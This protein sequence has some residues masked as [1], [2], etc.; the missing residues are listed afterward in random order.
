MN[1]LLLFLCSSIWNSFGWKEYS[2]KLLP[3]MKASFKNIHVKIVWETMLCSQI[4]EGYLGARAS[5]QQGVLV[6]L[7]SSRCSWIPLLSGT[8]ILP[9]LGF[10]WFLLPLAA[11]KN[12]LL[13]TSASPRL[14][15]SHDLSDLPSFRMSSSSTPTVKELTPSWNFPSQPQDRFS[16]CHHNWRK[17]KLEPKHLMGLWPTFG[18]T[19]LGSAAHPGAIRCEQGAKVLCTRPLRASCS[20]GALS[21]TICIIMRPWVCQGLWVLS[22]MVEASKV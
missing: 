20:P 7:P 18:L 12:F 6:T 14:T 17:K 11:L 8:Q 1:L 3:V 16:Y 13:L 4:L 9:C 21:M 2:L 5:S 22:C 19:A 15:L 10:R